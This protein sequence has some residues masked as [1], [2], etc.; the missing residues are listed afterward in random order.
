MILEHQAF[1]FADCA[2]VVQP[3]IEQL[4][5]IAVASATTA[6]NL[7]SIDDVKLALL[8]FSTHGS[9]KHP[10]S[11]K[12]AQA[13]ELLKSRDIDFDADGELQLD[14]AISPQVAQIKTTDSAVAG[15]ANVLIFPDLNAANIGYKLVQRLANAQAIG[16]ILQ[17]IAKPM[18]D[19]SRGANVDDIVNM[20]AITATQC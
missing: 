12:I 5:D 7:L 19:L 8:S 6:K 15:Q 14:A 20:V 13:T 9:G 17:G 11:E 3:T 10:L 4:A 2:V 16:P 1:I 18:N